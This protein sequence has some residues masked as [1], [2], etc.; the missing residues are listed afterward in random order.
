MQGLNEFEGNI[1]SKK[2]EVTL[3]NPYEENKTQKKIV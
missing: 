1:Y 3:A 2:Y